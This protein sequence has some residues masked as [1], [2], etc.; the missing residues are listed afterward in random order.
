MQAQLEARSKALTD[1]VARIEVEE[2]RW[3]T[4]AAEL[5]TYHH[6][7]LDWLTANEGKVVEDADALAVTTDVVSQQCVQ[8]PFIEHV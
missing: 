2:K 5:A 7:A 4:H 3:T 8:P 6:E 1:A